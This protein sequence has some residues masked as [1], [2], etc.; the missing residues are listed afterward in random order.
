MEGKTKYVSEWLQNNCVGKN[1]RRSNHNVTDTFSTQPKCIL[2]N[3]D[4]TSKKSSE[5]ENLRRQNLHLERELNEARNVIG[6]HEE[7]LQLY[8]QF[9][10]LTSDLEEP[11]LNVRLNV[12]YSKSVLTPFDHQPSL[13]QRQYTIHNQP[14]LVHHHQDTKGR[15]YTYA[16]NREPTDNRLRRHSNSSKRRREDDS[17]SKYSSYSSCSTSVDFDWGCGTLTVVPRGKGVPK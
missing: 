2:N 9:R 7:R 5:C 6:M 11:Q 14:P 1:D 12:R 13:F 3:G 15:F 8:S 17:R 16:E 4:R 10:P